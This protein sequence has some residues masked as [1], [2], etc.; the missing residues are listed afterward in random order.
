MG[1]SA[2]QVLTGVPGAATQASAAPQKIRLDARL[3]LLLALPLARPRLR[4]GQVETAPYGV[5]PAMVGHAPESKDAVNSVVARKYEHEVG[6]RRLHP[7]WIC[8]ILQQDLR[9]AFRL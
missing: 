5:L 4:D 7:G 1:R 3:Y 2:R 6:Q 9:L 8:P